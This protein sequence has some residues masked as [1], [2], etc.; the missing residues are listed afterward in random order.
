MKTLIG[1]DPGTNTG[2]ARMS[3]GK[4]EVVG[5]YSILNAI[6]LVSNSYTLHLLSHG[7]S[8]AGFVVYV[9]DARLRGGNQLA[10][11]LAGSIRRDCNIWQEF[12][13]ARKIP[14]QFVRPTKH[15]MTKLDSA[16]FARRTGWTGRTNEHGRD[17][18]ML[19]WGR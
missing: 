18:A 8:N 5:T 2:F 17:A 9:E 15:S 4:L 11:R 14:H 16:T 7:D 3:G 12:L 13:T 1:I 19:I 10:A 6:E